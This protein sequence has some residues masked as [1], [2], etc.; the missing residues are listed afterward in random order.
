MVCDGIA[1]AQHKSGEAGQ[2][3]AGQHV[4]EDV[5]EPRHDPDHQNGQDDD[6]HHQHCDGIEH[7]RDDL[8]L[9]FLRFFH[10]VRQAGQ[11]DFQ[12]AAQFAGLD[13]VHVEAVE[14]FGMLG[15]TFRKRAASFN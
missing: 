7:G 6:G 8:A 14:N 10:E 1:D 13:H 9:D 4:L 3:R 5:F 11:N 12:H 15:E 2:L